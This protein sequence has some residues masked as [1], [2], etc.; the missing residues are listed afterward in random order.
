MNHPRPTRAFGL[1][2]LTPLLACS[3]LASVPAAAHGAAPAKGAQPARA[4]L[5]SLFSDEDYPPEAVRNHEQGP[6]GFHLEIGKDGV[7]TDCSVTA[8][9]GSAILDSTTCRLIMERARFEPAR[10]SRGR[11]TSD[12]YSGRIVWRLPEDEPMPP[13]LEAAFTL[14]SLC[15]SGEAAKLASGDLPGDEIV[16]RSFAP[17]AALEARVRSEL[18]KPVSEEELRREMASALGGLLTKVRDQLK[19]PAEPPPAR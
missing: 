9:S 15:L 5:P 19:A 6:V 1:A 13:R 16:K 14:W 4:N 17:C 8:S 3:L 18:A 10:D 11:P 2:L 12:S 7:P